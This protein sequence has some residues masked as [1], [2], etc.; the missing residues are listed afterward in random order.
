MLRVNNLSDFLKNL[1]DTLRKFLPSEYQEPQNPQNFDRLIEAVKESG[2]EQGVQ[3][4]ISRN[5]KIEG[6]IDFGDYS[7]LGKTSFGD[8]TS[9]LSNEIQATQTI[10]F[11]ELAGEKAFENDPTYGNFYVWIDSIASS[12]PN[13]IIAYI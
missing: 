11:N 5:I 2:K 4:L 6:S 9:K 1:A 7:H 12:H 13:W 10:I 3:F 8:I